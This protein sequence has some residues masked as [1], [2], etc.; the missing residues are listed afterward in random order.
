MGEAL[1]VVNRLITLVP[2]RADRSPLGVLAETFVDYASLSLLLES[3]DHQV[4]FGRRGTGKTHAFSYHAQRVAGNGDCAILI[5]M[6]SLGSTTGIYADTSL[7]IHERGT[8]LLVDALSV[9]RERLL[10]FVVREVHDEA[11]LSTALAALAELEE[12]SV[13]VTVEG[14]TEQETVMNVESTVDKGTALGLSLGAQLGINASHKR[15]AGGKSETQERRR[16]TGVAR[17]R[18]RFGKV[19]TPIRLISKIVSPSQI[20]I[21]F[22]EWSVVPRDLQPLLADL[23]R[24][25]LLPI[26][27]VTIKIGAIEHRSLFAV[28]RSAGDYVGI[29]LGADMTANVNLDELVAFEREIETGA[30]FYGPLICG[31]VKAGA[32]EAGEWVPDSDEELLAEIFASPGA[33]TELSRAAEGVAR[34]AIAILQ[35]AAMRAGADKITARDVTLSAHVWHEQDKEAN[36][37]DRRAR[38]AWR[39]LLEM[40]VQDRH[41]RAFA[42]EEIEAQESE[43]IR[44][45]FDQRLIHL[46]KRNVVSR[47]NSGLRYYVFAIDYGHYAGS[48]RVTKGLFE[49]IEADGEQ[50]WAE[51]VRDEYPSLKPAVLFESDLDQQPR[52]QTRPLPAVEPP[53]AVQVPRDADEPDTSLMRDLIYLLRTDD[54]EEIR[55]P[56]SADQRRSAV[57]SAVLGRYVGDRI[58]VRARGGSWTAQI[59]EIR[60]LEQRPADEGP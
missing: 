5:D 28:N 9:I 60:L 57:G 34:D 17:H 39:R 20:W 26:D 3:R 56:V 14:E 23:I 35:K 53:S 37:E 54:G 25:V 7:P 52:R 36:L 11:A 33:L 32:A 19:A 2:T 50:K 29:E 13:R 6:R 59:I 8:R 10:E 40:V 16:A 58:E 30:A 18:V 31:H 51:F 27:G 45:L 1:S 22:D 4:V 48:T 42:L 12:E 44:T 49:F 41:A 24:R 55:V 15:N 47:D 46:V 21:L 38:D 43:R